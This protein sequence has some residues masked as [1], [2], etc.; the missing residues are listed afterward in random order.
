MPLP[1]PTF[2][3]VTPAT[4]AAMLGALPFRELPAEPK[5]E[6]VREA[7]PQVPPPAPI[8]TAA[9]QPAASSTSLRA[10]AP[11]AQAGSSQGLPA[12]ARTGWVIQVG[13]FEEEREARQKLNAVQAKAGPL[14]GR[15]SPFTEPV[16]KGDKTFYRA[17]FAG[18]QKDE[19]EAACRQ[20]KRN[21]IDCMT[22]RN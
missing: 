15:A 22:I 21:D 17:R 2:K 4:R 7:A 16:V 18:L 6:L 5:H 3:P 8:Q 14:L 10:P 11:P 9:I 12:A 1:E 19:A 13:A 20:L